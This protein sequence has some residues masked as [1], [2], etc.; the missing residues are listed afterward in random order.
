MVRF[1]NIQDKEAVVQR[2]FYFFDQ[3]PFMVRPWNEQLSIGT[4][5]ISSRSIW[6]KFPEL[7]IKYWGSDSLNKLISLLGIP[8]K[9]DKS[10]KD[11]T[12][13]N[14]A[15]MLI[16]VP[17]GGTFPDYVEFIND[18][19]ILVRQKAEFE[20]KPTKCTHCNLGDEEE[21]CRKKLKIR[22]E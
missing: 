20:W 8:F 3:K 10:T 17:L 22:R 15:R 1:A 11:K 16:D 13:L 6:V 18:Y 4:N 12:M 7:D 2:G 9:T 21:E 14:Y 19:D 5:S